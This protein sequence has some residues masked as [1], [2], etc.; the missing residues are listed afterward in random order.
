MS[1]IVRIGARERC[2]SIPNSSPRDLFVELVP[3]ASQSLLSMTIK[4]R[5]T[6]LSAPAHRNRDH[7]TV[8]S[9]NWQIGRI[10]EVDSSAKGLRWQWSLYGAVGGPRE[11][12]RSG[13][14]DTLDQANKQFVH[15]WRSWLA[16]AGLKDME[17]LCPEHPEPDSGSA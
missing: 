9:N 1:F 16:W 3:L 8:Y 6:G 13:S 4:L 7:W 12:K 15:S 14:A 17:E 10:F 2:F 5:A 11:I